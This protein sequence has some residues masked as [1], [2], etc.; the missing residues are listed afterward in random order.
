MKRMFFWT[1]ALS[2][3]ASGTAYFS[4]QHELLGANSVW[5]ES[6]ARYGP[7]QALEV[8]PPENAVPAPVALEEQEE[9][10]EDAGGATGEKGEGEAGP[11]PESRPE[12]WAQK[13]EDAGDA[14]APAKETDPRFPPAGEPVGLENY[15]LETRKTYVVQPGDTLSGIG[16][17]HLVPYP[18]LAKINGLEGTCIHAGAPL[19]VVEGPFHVLVKRNEKRLHLY[20]GGVLVE[21]WPVAVGRPGYET[22]LGEFRVRTKMDKPDWT[23]PANRRV[24]PFGDPENPLGTRWIGFAEGLGIHGTWEPESMGREAS[25]G[26]IRMRNEDVEVLFD[27][28]VRGESVVK[29]VAEA[30]APEAEEI[31]PGGEKEVES[32]PPVDD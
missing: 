15:L 32:A 7:S 31:S 9:S 16:K 4:V 2:G 28:L 22:K 24:V 8:S 21:T 19:A 27:L 14:K 29:I 18:L 25:H 30:A 1:M 5:I 10:G 23:D 17:A 6:K 20:C 13:D 11:D 3:L 26:C 12:P